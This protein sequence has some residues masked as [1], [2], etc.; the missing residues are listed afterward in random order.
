LG[1][2]LLESHWSVERHDSIEPFAREWDELADRL[3][4]PPWLRPAWFTAWW[5][6]FGRGMLRVFAVR[7]DRRL[8]GVVPVAT[9]RLG[10]VSSPTNWHTPEFGLLAEPAATGRL[11]RVLFDDRPECVSLAFV[12]VSSPAMAGVR[13]AAG[14]NGYRCLSRSLERSP[15]ITIDGDWESYEAGRSRKLLTELRRR[16]RRLADEGQFSFECVDGSERL[17]ELLD[18]GFRVEAAGWKGARHSAIMTK[19]ETDRFY[20]AVAR[21]AAEHGWLRLAF[22]RLDGRP[23]AF[24]FCV[25][26]DGVHYLLKTGFDPAYSRY[27]PGIVLRYEMIAR[28]F[29]DGLRSYEF[30][31]TNATWKLRWTDTTRE[32]G[33]LQAFAPSPRGLIDWAA[34]AYGRPLARRALGRA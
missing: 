28:A 34:N 21:L 23:F 30:L 18:E 11:A 16:R 12:D 33:A 14:E 1:E 31:G 6:A 32:L 8:V 26:H 19:V 4:A 22:L 7:D 2:R 15:Y 3:A 17:D 20:R 27:A 29:S 9:T 5:A 13:A 25:E 24:D 10:R